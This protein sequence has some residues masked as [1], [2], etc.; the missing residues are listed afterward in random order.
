[1]WSEK[2]FFSLMHEE[3]VGLIRDLF[4]GMFKNHSALAYAFMNGSPWVVKES[5]F[6]G[7]KNLKV[8][9]IEESQE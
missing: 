7:P 2:R 8:N 5:I 1:M 9:T 6:S 4:S 3:V